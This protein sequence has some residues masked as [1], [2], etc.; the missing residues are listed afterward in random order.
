MKRRMDGYVD[1]SDIGDFETLG[2]YTPKGLRPRIREMKPDH[3]DFKELAARNAKHRDEVAERTDLLRS[4]AKKL[5]NRL[6]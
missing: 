6:D 2:T 3:P 5:E 1:V 4:F